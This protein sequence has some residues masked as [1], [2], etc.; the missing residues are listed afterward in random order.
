MTPYRCIKPF[1][2]FIFSLIFLL[3]LGW[4]I[5]L[6][7]V[8]IK[9]DD[10]GSPVFYID[11]RVGKN[12]R[13]FRMYKLRTMKACC[14]GMDVPLDD[15]LTRPGRLIRRL[16]L[17][18]LPQLFNV[19]LGDMSFIGP[20]PLLLRYEPYYT[21]EEDRRH[22]VRPGITGLA[23]INGRANLAWDKRFAYDVRYV[24]SVSF[25]LD[26]KIALKTIQ[27]VIRRDDMVIPVDSPVI[28]SFDV[29]RKRKLESG[30][31]ADA[32]R[33]KTV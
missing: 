5:V 32:L 24:E 1:L 20:R 21:A 8:L 11:T 10:P 4:L 18:E 28:A 26:L 14:T 23:Q 29:W 22:L 15:T 25:L 2:S 27:K 3:L 9:L 30:P 13:H 16:S 7:A 31:P 19:L 12:R 17:D 33:R 6:C